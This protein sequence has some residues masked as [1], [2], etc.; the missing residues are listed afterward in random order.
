MLWRHDSLEFPE[1][2]QLQCQLELTSTSR[3]QTTAVIGLGLFSYVPRRLQARIKAT[4][5]KIRKLSFS[6][7]CS[8]KF[9]GVLNVILIS[10]WCCCVFPFTLDYM[11]FYWYFEHLLIF[12][13][14]FYWSFI[15]LLNF[16]YTVTEL[17]LFFYWP[18]S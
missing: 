12:F 11:I 14:E 4:D 2:E 1:T 16:Y 17:L 9:H 10:I 3:C 7:G 6:P 15:E 5:I 8:H 13:S 18:I